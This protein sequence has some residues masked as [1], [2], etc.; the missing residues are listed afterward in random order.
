MGP[1]RAL[2]L[3][4]VS[5][6]ALALFGCAP[7]IP[8][9]APAIPAPP[10]ALAEAPDTFFYASPDVRIRF[11][12]TGQ[13]A[14]VILIHG[15]SR[16]LTDWS[17]VGDSLARDHRVIAFDVRGFGSSTR[18]S[19]R[20]QLGRE[21]ANDVIKLLDLLEIRRAHLVGHSMGA[22]IAAYVAAHYPDRVRSV[23]LIAGPFGEDTTAFTRDEAGF[24]ADIEQGRG[25]MKLL[26]WLFPTY[27]D[28][29]L[30][31]WN[32]EASAANDPATVGAAMRSVDLLSVLPS[33][34]RKIRAPALVVV[35]TG[36]PL[37]P[38]SRWIASWWPT[39]RLVEV[40][41]ADHFTILN[42]PYVLASMR[43]LMRASP[44]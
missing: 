17:G 39:A 33:A 6:V 15:L 42:H 29:T 12:E 30:A 4:L 21:M 26:R 3:R 8:V 7:R 38:Q 35:G 24:A 18:V 20:A 37:V 5:L 11:R 32:T 25:M 2:R 13:G 27:P 19:T 10:I 16:S 1:R 22:S 9:T 34:A 28:S 40:P 44:P 41:A 36:D 31:A 23:S 14:T 43:M